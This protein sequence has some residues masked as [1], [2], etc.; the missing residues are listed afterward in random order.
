[1]LNNLLSKWFLQQYKVD[2]SDIGQVNVAFSKAESCV[3]IRIITAKSLKDEEH[4]RDEDDSLTS[5]EMMSFCWQIAQG[6][7]RDWEKLCP[8]AD[9]HI[10]KSS[11][12]L[13]L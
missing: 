13:G 3:D 4:N 8:G 12:L 11:Y 6:M 10:E 1:M 7:V 2:T 9:S 5:Q